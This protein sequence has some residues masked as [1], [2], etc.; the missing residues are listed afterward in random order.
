M[1]RNYSYV[2]D[3]VLAGCAQPGEYYNFADDLKQASKDGVL[4]LISLTEYS[5]DQAV[6]EQSGLR[7]LHL[8]IIDF[9]APQIAQIKQFAQFVDKTRS[10]G[11]ASLVHC[12]AGIGRTGTML[13]AYLVHT[14][15]PAKEA[16]RCVRTQRPGSLE[17]QD[18]ENII[19]EYAELLENE[20]KT[21][22]KQGN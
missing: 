6:I 22:K 10:G 9:S 19:F 17:T 5:L 1:L 13:A 2:I 18:Q 20:Q 16:L 7:Y 15:M 4:A 21:P 14:G 12:H 8:P 11:G 3:N